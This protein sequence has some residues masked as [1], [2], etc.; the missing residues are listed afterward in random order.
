MAVP[1]APLDAIARLG[2]RSAA[3]A[4]A[5]VPDPFIIAIGLGA[6][7]LVSG[8]LVGDGP[9]LEEHGLLGLVGS[10][11][12]GMMATGLLAFAF[13]MALVLV[14]G[15]ALAAAPAMR[16]LLE[17]VAGV[18]R[19]QG[20]A[21]ATVALV[22]IV[23]GLLNWG[24]G[25]VGGAFLARE[26]GRAFARRG[27]PLNYAL[28][29]AAGYVGMMTWHGGLSGSAPLTVA[30]QGAFGDAIDVSET[31]FSLLNLVTTGGLVVVVPA[32]LWALAQGPATLRPL[33]ASLVEHTPE[34]DDDERPKVGAQK[35]ESSL[36]VTLLLALPIV[37]ALGVHLARE[38]TGAINLNLIILAFFA[39]GLVLHKSPM[40]YARAFAEGSAGA[41]GILLQFPLYFGIL[42]VMRDSGML[43]AIARGLAG[44]AVDLQGVVPLDVSASWLT[45]ASAAF[46]NMLVPSGGGQWALQAPI[47]LETARDLALDKAP[48]VMAFSYGDQLT[49]MLQP[50]WALPL[51]SI[52]GLKARD[53]L[54][55][56]ILVMCVS[57][58]VILAGLLLS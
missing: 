6:L 11:V 38:G 42:A 48:L 4:Q 3:L 36:V 54:G 13:Q 53:V 52:T 51:L 1:S 15:H 23:L 49:N 2:A 21:A 31:L 16:R 19:T 46:I 5:I 39:A 24:L 47:I 45:F 34:G 7:T 55:Y 18:P 22:T 8:W 17:R 30:T 40:G 57:I 26:V 33:P 12:D 14:T 37:V 9:V 28:I 35:L 43:V 50:F 56:T 25:L 44:L 29:G 27:E 58:P 32:F 20:A 10:Y 41:G